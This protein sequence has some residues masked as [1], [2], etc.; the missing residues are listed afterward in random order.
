VTLLDAALHAP[1]PVAFCALTLKVYAV[2]FVRPLTVMGD[3]A[4]V[5]VTHPGVDVAVYPVIPAGVPVQAGAVNVM[6]AV[7]SPA[8]AVPIVG[9]PGSCGHS[10]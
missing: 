1:K 6:L 7:V 5:P 8:V 3:D 9:A 4:A 2:P 10:P